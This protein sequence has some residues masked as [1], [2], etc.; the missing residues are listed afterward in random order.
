MVICPALRKTLQI[1]KLEYRDQY[2]VHIPASPKAGVLFSTIL[3]D[4]SNGHENCL[5]SHGRV[6]NS[7][8]YKIDWYNE[9]SKKI[10]EIPQN[11]ANLCKMFTFETGPVKSLE[12]LWDAEVK[13][14]K[15][16]YEGRGYYLQQNLKMLFPMDMKTVWAAMEE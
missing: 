8:P 7:C 14:M 13:I 4:V 2:L 6:T 9:E 15:L 3:E 10:A 12:E 16:D 1:I 5:G 11:R